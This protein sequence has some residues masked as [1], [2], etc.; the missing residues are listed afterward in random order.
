MNK[1]NNQFAHGLDNRKQVIDLILLI[2]K[3]VIN[4]QN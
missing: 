3:V 4:N 1:T 2:N